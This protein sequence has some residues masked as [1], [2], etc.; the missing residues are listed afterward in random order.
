MKRS[1][2]VSRESFE[3][4][5]KGPGSNSSYGIYDF[6]EYKARHVE[7]LSSSIKNLK[8]HIAE[9]QARYD[10]WKQSHEWKGDEWVALKK[11]KA[12]A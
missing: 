11:E 10:G 12:K 1:F 3:E 2:N 4:F 7:G 5:K 9:E 6:D 8:A